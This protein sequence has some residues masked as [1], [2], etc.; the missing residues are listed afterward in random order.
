G[1]ADGRAGL[2]DGDLRRHPAGPE[3]GQLPFSNDRGVAE[4]GL[5]DIL[6][7]DRPRQAKMHRRAVDGRKARRDLH[8]PDS[9]GRGER[10]HRHYHLALEAPRRHAVDAAAVH[11]HDGVILDVPQ[12]D[13]GLQD[14]QLEGER[15]AQHEGD[16]IVGPVFA[17]VGGLIDE[18]AV[19]ENAIARHVGADVDVAQIGE[20][21][22]AWRAHADTG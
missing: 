10:A 7:A 22:I 13:A 15:A 18:L 19:L 9:V 16:E 17:D 6:D 8:R 2:L 4:I 20:G 5:V 3:Y 1:N 11:G 14:R 21:G 12:T